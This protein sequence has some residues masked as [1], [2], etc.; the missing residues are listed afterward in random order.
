MALAFVGGGWPPRVVITADQPGRD[1][2]V[3]RAVA[4][5]STG[6]RPWKKEKNGQREIERKEK[7]RG[8]EERKCA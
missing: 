7:R 6:T 2:D 5:D 4:E 8:K 3:E 1:N